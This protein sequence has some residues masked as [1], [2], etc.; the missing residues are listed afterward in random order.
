MKLAVASGK[1]GTGKTMVAANLGFT[2]ARTCDVTLVDCDVEEP[3]LHLFFPSPVTTRDVT[4]PVPM[5]DEATCDH[6][7]RCGEFCQYG[8]ITVLRD[9]ILF[10]S[11]SATHAADAR[12]SARKEPF[13]RSQN[14]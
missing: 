3:N 1:G 2:L 6:C 10:F 4:V 12:W 11:D 14:G 7:G 8:A 9:R 13:M 5:I